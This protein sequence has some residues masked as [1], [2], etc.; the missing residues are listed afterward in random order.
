MR[1][2]TLILRP[3]R[4]SK[5]SPDASSLSLSR[6]F[7]YKRLS[8]NE[9]HPINDNNAKA[10]HNAPEAPPPDLPMRSPSFVLNKSIKTRNGIDTVMHQC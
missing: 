8:L 10:H 9:S 1:Q 6:A 4:S 7:Y 2:D 3:K 5:I